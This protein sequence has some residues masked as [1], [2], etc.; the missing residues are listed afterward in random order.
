MPNRGAKDRKAKRQ[1]LNIDF[2]YKEDNFK[3]FRHDDNFCG[4]INLFSIEILTEI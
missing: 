3:Y 1:Q 2:Y 4:F